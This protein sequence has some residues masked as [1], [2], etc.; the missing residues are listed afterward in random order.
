MALIALSLPILPGKEAKWQEMMDQ[1]ESG[2]MKDRMDALRREVGVHE[3]TFLQ[4]GPHGDVVIVTIE[5]DDPLVAFG[6]MMADPSMRDF[7]AW[8]A[9][10]HGLDPDAP[11]PAPVLIYDS[12][13]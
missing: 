2:P 1:I 3:R 13:A 12:E 11:P 6:R 10:V 5:G 8:A 4:E 9:D 7:A